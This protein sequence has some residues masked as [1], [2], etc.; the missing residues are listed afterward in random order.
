MFG[1]LLGGY[2]E[3][4]HQDV[5]S[6]PD[7]RNFATDAKTFGDKECRFRRYNA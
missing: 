3:Q 7:S 2:I 5:E 1:N 4:L 6:L